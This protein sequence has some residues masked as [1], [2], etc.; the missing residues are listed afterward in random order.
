VQK[1][2]E[3][4]SCKTVIVGGGMAGLA[5]AYELTQK[6]HSVILAEAHEIGTGS[7]GWCGGILST[8]TTVDFTEVEASFGLEPA[9]HIA[10]SLERII[11]KYRKKFGN[12]CLWQN[13]STLFLGNKKGDEA[14]LRQEGEVRNRYGLSGHS[15]KASTI[16]KHWDSRYHALELQNENAVHPVQLSYAIAQEILAEGGTIHEHAKVKDWSHD[17]QQFLIDCGECTIRSDNLIL[18]TGIK[19]TNSPRLKAFRRLLLPVTGH[20][21]VTEPSVQVQEL[22]S[23][24][25]VVALWDSLILYHYVRYLPDGRILIGG[26]DLPESTRPTVLDTS[27]KHIQDLYAWAQR[28]HNFP[29]PAIQSCWRASMVIPFDGMPVLA[30]EQI[31]AGSLLEV[32]TDGLPGSLLLADTVADILSGRENRIA[33]ILSPMRKTNL[34]AKMFS[35]FPP[36]TLIRKLACKMAFAAFRLKD[37]LI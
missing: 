33:S 22:M 37:A 32:V 1:L 19:G 6:G 12:K 2:N 7:T 15:K 4:V 25:N 34:P 18:C 16:V 23:S 11:A 27:D 31:G 30:Q 24:T 36:D 9:R 14:K 35:L 5:I 8:D 3:N 21:L 17:G 10:S 20:V 13:G 26:E 28:I 29:L